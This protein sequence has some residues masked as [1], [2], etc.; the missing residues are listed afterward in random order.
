MNWSAPRDANWLVPNLHCST[1]EDVF[2]STKASIFISHDISAA[3]EGCTDQGGKTS[4]DNLSK[5]IC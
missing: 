4:P 3:Y 1:T 5:F 2:L